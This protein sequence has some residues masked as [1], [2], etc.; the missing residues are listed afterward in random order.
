[1]HQ[2]TLSRETRSY[3]SLVL[4]RLYH[5]LLYELYLVL[6]IGNI[7][8]YYKQLSSAPLYMR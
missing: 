2:Q 3:S 6:S 5:D 7:E 1:M 4:I 8:E